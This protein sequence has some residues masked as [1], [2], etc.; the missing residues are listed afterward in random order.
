MSS[1]EPTADYYNVAI[2]VSTELQVGRGSLIFIRED[3]LTKSP[4]FGFVFD[5][6]WIWKEKKN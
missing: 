6:K 5:L 1:V 4:L 2:T 3:I